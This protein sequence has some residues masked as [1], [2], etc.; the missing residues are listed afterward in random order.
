MPR[1]T[2]GAQIF[3]DMIMDKGLS[4]TQKILRQLT[5]AVK[6]EEQ[7]YLTDKELKQFAQNNNKLQNTRL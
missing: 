5:I 7:E 2:I 6:R 1:P 3:N 4:T